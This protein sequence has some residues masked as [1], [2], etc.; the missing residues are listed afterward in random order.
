MTHLSCHEAPWYVLVPLIALL[1]AAAGVV[2]GLLTGLIKEIL[3]GR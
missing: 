3:N 1:W 2:L